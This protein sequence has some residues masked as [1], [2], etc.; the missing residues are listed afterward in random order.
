MNYFFIVLILGKFY[1]NRNPHKM[2]FGVVSKRKN[3]ME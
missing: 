1:G 2:K 3:E